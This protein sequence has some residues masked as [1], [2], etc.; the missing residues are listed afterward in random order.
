[1]YICDYNVYCVH[2]VHG[3]GCSSSSINVLYMV[4][5]HRYRSVG[6][7]KAFVLYMGRINRNFSCFSLCTEV[8]TVVSYI[9]SAPLSFYFSLFHSLFHSILHLQSSNHVADHIYVHFIS[10]TKY[11]EF[12]LDFDKLLFTTYLFTCFCSLA[13]SLCVRPKNLNHK[14]LR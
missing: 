6:L 12:T 7:V 1:M 11:T 4:C 14:T 3:V 8:C 5:S 10:Y 9:V 2:I 13:L